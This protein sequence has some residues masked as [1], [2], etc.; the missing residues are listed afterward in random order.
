MTGEERPIRGR[1]M[2][3]GG[4]RARLGLSAS[5]TYQLTRRRDFP[6]PV[7]HLA[8]GRIWLKEDV[9]AWIREHRPGRAPTPSA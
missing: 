8:R 5:R 7:D 3:L 2:C 4:I 9:E 1:L 6:E